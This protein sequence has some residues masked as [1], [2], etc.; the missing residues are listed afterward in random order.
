MATWRAPARVNLIGDHVDYCGGLVLPFALALTTTATVTAGDDGLVQVRSDPAGSSVS[1]PANTNVGEVCG[2][3]GYVAGVVWALANPATRDSDGSDRRTAIRRGL[4]IHLRSDV[5]L[6]TGL[7]SSAALEC[8]VAAAINE[9]FG[10]GLSGRR[11]AAAAHRAETEYVG[12]R[13][14]VMDQLA[15]MLC[16]PDH[17]L[18][19]DCRSLQTQQIPLDLESAG[20][21]LLVIDTGVRRELVGSEYAERRS[22]CE[23][24]TAALG[25]ATLRDVDIEHADTLTEPVLRRRARHVVSE[26]ERVRDVVGLLRSGRPQ[27]IGAVLTASHRSLRDDFEVSCDELDVAVDAA[28][29]GGALGARLTGGG[30]GGC[31]IALCRDGEAGGVGDAVAAAYDAHGWPAATSWSISPSAGAQRVDA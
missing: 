13:T 16:E 27:D 25:A 6:G 5:P 9:E 17:A 23:E 29:S 14:G 8:S 24:A 10:L 19:L 31:V 22:A 2:W 20:L 15:C 30:F 1:F 28:L 12:A 7:S 4:R 11:L 21:S 26:I 18:L 3:G